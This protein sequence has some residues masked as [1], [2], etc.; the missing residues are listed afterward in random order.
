[1]KTYS[2]NDAYVYFALMFLFY[3]MTNDKLSNHIFKCSYLLESTSLIP[4]IFIEV[5]AF[6][7]YYLDENFQFKEVGLPVKTFFRDRSLYHKE[8]HL[9]L[10][11]LLSQTQQVLEVHL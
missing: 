9:H 11:R 3:V 7:N 10:C 5:E 1:M 6:I 8:A 4:L 2:V